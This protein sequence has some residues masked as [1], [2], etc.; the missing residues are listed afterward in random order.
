MGHSRIALVHALTDS[1]QPAWAAFADAWPEARIHN[2]LDDSLA[3][4]LAV[5]GKITERMI[6]RFLA[7]GRYAASTGVEGD[8]TSAILF[9][10][11]A[12][13]PAI[14]RVKADLDIPVLRPNEAAFE[15]ALDAGS[16]IGLMVSFP[17]AL[18]PLVDELEHMARSRGQRIEVRTGIAAGALEALKAG[19]GH[20]HDALVAA[21]AETLADVDA[22]VLCQFSLARAVAG[23]A[24]VPGRTV[25]STP[26]SAVKKLRRTLRVS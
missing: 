21:C 5:E 2:V 20:R 14:D 11:S 22:L 6:G 7:I 8:E 25:L 18:P 24:P 12:F 13:G 26:V 3:R 23:V 10:C 16:R 9:T 15:E 1:Q 17:K 4:D 19:D